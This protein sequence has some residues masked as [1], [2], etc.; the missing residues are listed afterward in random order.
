MKKT[1]PILITLSGKR[2]PYTPEF[3]TAEEYS[4]GWQSVLKRA[5]GHAQLQCQC[6]G[7]GKK[8]ISIKSLNG[9]KFFLARYPSSGRDHSRLCQYFDDAPGTGIDGYKIGVIDPQ[10]DGSVKIKLDFGMTMRTPASPDADPDRGTRGK[11]PG[12]SKSAMKL[13]GLLH[14]L[15]EDC[16]LNHWHPGFAGKRKSHTVFYWINGAAEKIDVG[17]VRLDTLLL[18]P[19][20]KESKEALQNQARVAQALAGKNRMLIVATLAAYS[21]AKDAELATRLSVS[22]FYG[23]PWTSIQPGHWDRAK[24]RFPGTVAGW[25]KGQKTVVIAQIELKEKTGAPTATVVSMALMGVTNEWISVESS[26]EAVVADLLIAQGRSFRKPLSYTAEEEQVLPDFV[27]TD[28]GRE[29][30]MEVFGRSDDAYLERKAEKGRHYNENYG[31]TGWWKWDAAQN[32]S[33]A[34]IPKFPEKK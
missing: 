24:I 15:W 34:A 2:T 21:P 13:F 20:M 27:L 23:I 8:R 14:F 1:F 7:S 3:Q 28:A 17:G 32:S 9:D 5:Y 19:A 12:V 10:D 6:A 31:P 11:K 18:L 26:F 16:G 4:K 25:R 22:S 33:P 29:V 30:P